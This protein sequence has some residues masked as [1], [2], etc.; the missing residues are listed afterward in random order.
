MTD[1]TMSQPTLN[2]S[3]KVKKKGKQD[4]RILLPSLILFW[5]VKEPYH[6]AEV[7]TR[8][9]HCSERIS[10]ARS[11]PVCATS[12]DEGIPHAAR[13]LWREK[14]RH[15]GKTVDNDAVCP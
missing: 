13:D 9:F 6:R 7:Q 11:L 3:K 14:H 12:G 5:S 10:C 15:L 4:N 1:M 2:C 8:R